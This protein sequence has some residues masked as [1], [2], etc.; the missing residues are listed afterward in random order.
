MASIRPVYRALAVSRRL[1]AR[2][3]ATAHQ[4]SWKES[5]FKASTDPQLNGYPDIPS[6]SYQLRPAKGWD[7][8]QERRNIGE[9]VSNVPEC[10]V[11]ASSQRVI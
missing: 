7:D 10:S 9:P 8:V 6:S 1:P 2:S 3:Y 4:P 11:M 5:D